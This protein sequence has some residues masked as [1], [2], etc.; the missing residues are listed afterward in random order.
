[1]RFIKCNLHDVCKVKLCTDY[2]S[3]NLTGLVLNEKKNDLFVTILEDE[4]GSVSYAVG[5]NIGRR[6]IYDCMKQ[7]SLVLNKGNL[8]ICC[9]ANSIFRRINTAAKLNLKQQH[10]IIKLSR[11]V[12]I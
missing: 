8:S 10:Q 11:H 7:N 1:M 3:K 12:K 9:G 2:E 5:I 4:T 6:L